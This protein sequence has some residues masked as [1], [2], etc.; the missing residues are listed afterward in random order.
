MAFSAS[1]QRAKMVVSSSKAHIAFSNILLH[2]TQSLKALIDLGHLPTR[3]AREKRQ[4][5]TAPI[6]SNCLYQGTKGRH[7]LLPITF[8]SSENPIIGE[9]LNLK[10]S[11]LPL[12]FILPYC[13]FK[14]TENLLSK[15]V[16]LSLDTLIVTDN[17]PPPRR[18]KVSKGFEPQ[19]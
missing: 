15:R 8:T 17:L 19:R 5:F 13:L 12:A 14:E 9:G 11:F 7:F 4:G 3:V 16:I 10:K 2:F 18:R 1:G 6:S